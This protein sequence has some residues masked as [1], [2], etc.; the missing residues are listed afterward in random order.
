MNFIKFSYRQT[1][2]CTDISDLLV[3]RF[4]LLLYRPPKQICTVLGPAVLRIRA[5]LAKNQNQNKKVS[6]YKLKTVKLVRY[7]DI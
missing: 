1:F 3:G 2:I 5:Q 7:G 4:F 6:S